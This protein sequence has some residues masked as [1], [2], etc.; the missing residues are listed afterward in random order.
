MLIKVLNLFVQWQKRFKMQFLTA[1]SINSNETPRFTIG[2][3][4]NRIFPKRSDG[5]MSEKRQHIVTMTNTTKKSK[6]LKHYAG[7]HLHLS[8]A[9]VPFWLLLLAKQMTFL[10]YGNRSRTHSCTA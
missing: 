9:S 5:S 1:R 8:R 10:L 6:Y 2:R 4:K 7:S 3:P